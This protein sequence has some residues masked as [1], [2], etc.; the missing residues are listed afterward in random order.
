[1]QILLAAAT[2]NE[3]SPT[4][5]WLSGNYGV[6]VLI[7]GIGSTATAFAL[8]KSILGQ[9]PDI[10]IQA[11]I[12]GSFSQQYPPGSVVFID[13][14]IIADMGAIEQGRLID[15]FDMGFAAGN[16]K[17]FTNRMLANPST[18][19]YN[20]GV[21]FVRGATVN[22]ISSSSLQVSLIKEKYNPVV[23]SMEGAA[24]HYVC[25]MESIPFLQLRAVSNLVGERNKA[26]WKFR[27]AI[28][29]LNE[30]LNV[31]ITDLTKE[32]RT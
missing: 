16:E 5:E 25:L 29:N 20:Y 11:G 17:P 27:E 32:T 19:K 9:R 23:E 2:V 1:M 14:E 10:V 30:K 8:T 22:G 31:I 24:L 13:E 12:A 4:M 18:A 28:T 26:N 7:T 6:K 3:I 15:I 21:D